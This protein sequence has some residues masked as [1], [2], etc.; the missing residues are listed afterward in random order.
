MGDEEILALFL[1]LDEWLRGGNDRRQ[2]CFGLRLD[3]ATDRRKK[4]G[5]N[6]HDEP[7]STYL[8]Q[9]LFVESV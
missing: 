1:R 2:V 8:K 9:N 4:D 5:G 3:S 7:T 6:Y